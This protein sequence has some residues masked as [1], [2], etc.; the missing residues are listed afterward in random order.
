MLAT[1]GLSVAAVRQR[2]IQLANERPQTGL[3][4]HPTVLEDVTRNQDEV[5]LWYLPDR[6]LE[7]PGLDT[8][9]AGPL[10]DMARAR[11]PDRQVEALGPD[12][13][14]Y[15]IFVTQVRPQGS[16]MDIHTDGR[17][18]AIV[19]LSDPEHRG[20]T[21]LGHPDLR[22]YS[23]RLTLE[24]LMNDHRTLV[25]RIF[26][27][28]AVAFDTTKIPHVGISEPGESGYRVILDTD[29]RMVGDDPDMTVYQSYESKS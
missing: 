29:Y 3:V 5:S 20:L 26:P 15:C 7:I 25:Q 28:H 9:Y 17:K 27:G 19:N 13:D 10:L 21:L 12:Q 2:A 23:G 6:T 16:R 11:V 22:R 8:L 14:R 18:S 1:A 24:M 4:A